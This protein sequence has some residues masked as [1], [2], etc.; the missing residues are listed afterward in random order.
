MNGL[1]RSYKY[2]YKWLKVVPART[3]GCKGQKTKYLHTDL[4]IH[5][6]DLVSTPPLFNIG[7]VI[8]VPLKKKDTLLNFLQ[9]EQV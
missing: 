5:T 4:C 6:N 3:Y 7:L 2:K 1:S 9:T 8:K